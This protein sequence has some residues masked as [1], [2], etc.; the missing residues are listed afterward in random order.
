[1]NFFGLDVE[2]IN[3]EDGRWSVVIECKCDTDAKNAIVTYFRT[4]QD[5]MVK[6]L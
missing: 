6:P 4:V 1:M 2:A 5:Y 3:T